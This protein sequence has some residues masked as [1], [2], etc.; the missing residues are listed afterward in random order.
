ML[1]VELLREIIRHIA[2]SDADE[3]DEDADNELSLE[4]S[5][6]SKQNWNL[7]SALSLSSKTLRALVLEVWFRVLVIKDPPGK[8]LPFPEI[9]S[10]WTREIYFIHVE[11]LSWN[12]NR[13]WNINEFEKVTK[14]RI[15]TKISP[16]FASGLKVVEAD[17]RDIAWPSPM[18]IVPISTSFPNLRIL[19]LRQVRV[20]CGLCNTCNIPKFEYP[21]PKYVRYEGGYG[22][23]SHYTTALAS[24]VNLEAV[25]LTVGMLQTGGS[26]LGN[27]EDEN[28]HLWSGEC[29]RCMEI[30]YAD[31]SFKI[32]WLAKKTS[33]NPRPPR[34]SLVEW[35]F[36][37]KKE[38]EETPWYEDGVET[39]ESDTGEEE[40]EMDDSTD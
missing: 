30:M 17:I 11:A 31:E 12:I 3:D 28:P 20:W 40:S 22:L 39:L 21:G 26:T 25:Y 6:C 9:R 19:R 2:V 24:L 37:T 14:V 36:W 32:K 10:S 29:D 8:R 13:S 16:H 38:T 5:R 7:Y 1:P 27:E 4:R 35:Y 15:D 23:P 18:F 33:V 34:L